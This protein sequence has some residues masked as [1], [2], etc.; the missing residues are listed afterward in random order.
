MQMKSYMELNPSCSGGS[1]EIMWRLTLTNGSEIV[2][3]SNFVQPE[4]SVL[5]LP[6]D[7]LE[8]GLYILH[9]EVVFPHMGPE[10]WAEDTTIIKVI[11][12]ELIT[13]IDGGD[14]I[15]ATQGDV[16][17]ITATKSN[18]PVTTLT[19]VVSQPLVATWSVAYFTSK[20]DMVYTHFFL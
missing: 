13:F 20:P 2:D 18:D 1:P 7:S 16:I 6:P 12:P 19:S 4:T 3:V 15:D 5:R 11:L 14:K 8:P 9:L 10:Y 17:T